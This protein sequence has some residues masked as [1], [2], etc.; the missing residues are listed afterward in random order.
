MLRMALSCASGT[1]RSRARAPCSRQGQFATLL[2]F[3][4]GID[5]GGTKTVCLLADGG[6]KYLSTHAWAPE[7]EVA[8]KQVEETLWW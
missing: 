1:P 2:M 4:L 7:L 5:A 6:W 8:E 3:V